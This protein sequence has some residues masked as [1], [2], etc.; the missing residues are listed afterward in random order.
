MSS[1]VH[2]HS[3]PLHLPDVLQHLLTPTLNTLFFEQSSL[4]RFVYS[5]CKAYTADLLPSFIQLQNNFFGSESPHR[6]FKGD[7]SAQI[8]LIFQFA[9]VAGLAAYE[10]RTVKFISASSLKFNTS[11]LACTP[12]I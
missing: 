8:L 3:T 12:K 2:L 9:T 1:V 11:Y 10:E 5:C 7:V 6:K 4:G